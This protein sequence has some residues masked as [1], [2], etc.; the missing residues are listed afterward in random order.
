M[1]YDDQKTSYKIYAKPKLKKFKNPNVIYTINSVMSLIE[2]IAIGRFKWT[3]IDGN[4][5]ALSRKIEEY[6]F[7]F[8]R[9]AI[10]ETKE[11]GL[12]VVRL[13][14]IGLNIYGEPAGYDILT[15]NGI[16]LT[17]LKKR[18]PNLEGEIG[19]DNAIIL[20]DSQIIT[21]GGIDGMWHWV[22]MIADAQ[23]S[24]DQQMINQR[25]PLFAYIK[26]KNQEQIA[27]VEMI[28]IN[29]GLNALI[30]DS[31]MADVIKPFNLEGQ[32]NVDKINA[33]QHEYL[34]RALASIG[35]DSM[36]S[37]GKKERLIVDE[38]E[39]NDEYLAMILV[40]CLN[41]RN[42]PLI[43]NETAKKYGIKCELSKPQRIS[44]YQQNQIDYTPVI[45]PADESIIKE[46]DEKKTIDG[47]ISE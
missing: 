10:V 11:V 37:F 40:D 45:V 7:Y 39:S 44:T 8:K 28:D 16:K 46:I 19:N 9:C 22:V 14:P 24:V 33:M 18:A 13:I 12:A 35:V 43:N 3:G 30:I 21:R 25:S 17:P 23:I 36:Q 1:N 41:A 15:T 31:S 42:D 34:S 26:D 27:N 32:F 5:I 38:A 6:L 29:T 47:D 4:G 20:T 2:R